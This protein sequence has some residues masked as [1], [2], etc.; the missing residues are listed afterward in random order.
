MKKRPKENKLQ[1]RNLKAN[2]ILRNFTQSIGGIVFT[3]Q[4]SDAIDLLLSCK[5]KVITTG[6]GKAGIAMRKFTSTLCSLG[7]ASCYLHPGE[8]SHGDLGLIQRDDILFV[9]STS[10]KTREVM[11]IIQ[12]ARKLNVQTIIGITSHPDS[13]IRQEADLVLDMG[14]L[15]EAGDLKMAPTTSILVILAITDCLSIIA[16]EERGFSKEDFGK[17]HHSGYLGGIARG[18]LRIQ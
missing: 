12:L 10:G 7:F 9:A 13:Y 18:D 17:F 1:R 6:M 11:E 14:I 5:G 16:S 15:E 4:F 2:R 8:A 3:S